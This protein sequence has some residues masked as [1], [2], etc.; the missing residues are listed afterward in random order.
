MQT[1]AETGHS[2][3]AAHAV[4]VV[5]A[6]V[7]LYCAEEEELR[8]A[9][10]AVRCPALWHTAR[11]PDTGPQQ[12]VARTHARS[13]A[14]RHRLPLKFAQNDCCAKRFSSV[15]A[16]SMRVRCVWCRQTGSACVRSVSL[17]KRERA[18]LN[19][20][21]EASDF[22]TP[23][24]LNGVCVSNGDCCSGLLALC[25]VERCQARCC[26]ATPQKQLR[27]PRAAGG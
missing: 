8:D 14:A 21:L 7:P 26:S 19:F 10:M 24:L 12:C 22:A 5:N 4:L 2:S 17:P 1:T 6:S 27:R 3:A 20:W 9:D 16:L 25:A 15:V 18:G 13:S 23:Q 11:H